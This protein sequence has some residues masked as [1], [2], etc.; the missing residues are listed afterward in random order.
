MASWRPEGLEANKG[1]S[2]VE[3]VAGAEDL[4]GTIIKCAEL[5]L[6]ATSM[7]DY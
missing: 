4:K 2:E 7:H 5:S 1:G 3:K 6:Y